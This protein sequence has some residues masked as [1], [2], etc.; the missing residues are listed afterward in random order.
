MEYTECSKMLKPR[1]NI[2]A[3]AALHL[4][5]EKAFCGA[6]QRQQSQRLKWIWGGIA[7]VSGVAAVLML[8]FLP[9]GISAQDILRET[10]HTL[11]SS[12]NIEMTVEIRTRPAEHF[13]HIDVAE[14]FVRHRINVSQTD[15]MWQWRVDKGG[16]VAV[17]NGSDYYMW[18]DDA[19]LGWHSSD[20]TWNI[21]GYLSMLVTPQNILEAEVEQ[22]SA[23]DKAEYAIEKKGGDILLTIHSKAYGDFRNAYLLNTS[24]Q[25]S[26]NIRRYKIDA[27]SKQIK[28]ASVSVVSK[29]KETEVLR[30]TEIRYGAVDDCIASLPGDV[31]FMEMD[32][33]EQAFSGIA[34]ADAAEAAATFLSAFQSWNT[35]VICKMMS[36]QEAEQFKARFAGS[37]LKSIGE[38]FKSGM[39][40]QLT[41]VP[42]CLELDDGTEYRHNLALRFVNNGNWLFD[43][44]L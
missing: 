33:D 43:G 24:I 15:S 38:P 17:K 20:S 40:E 7:T 41:F 35:V 30:I 21:L 34:G 9:F 4:K 2:K 22:A 31:H 16:R 12:K 6:K 37:T 11:Q 18:I 36:G 13:E 1:R 5:V 27:V 25:E 42:Y 39:N 32:S 28:S 29:R 3:S 14:D 19:K 26:E 44:G 10:L 23:D 8:V